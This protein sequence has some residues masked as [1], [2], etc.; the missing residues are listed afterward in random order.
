MWEQVLRTPQHSDCSR[1]AYRPDRSFVSPQSVILSC[2]KLDCQGPA[3]S[4]QDCLSSQISSPLGIL[5]SPLPVGLAAFSSE[6]DASWFV[7]TREWAAIYNLSNR[8][9]C[10][11]H[12]PK[13]SGSSWFFLK[14]AP[15]A[16][17][18]P[19]HHHCWVVLVSDL[20]RFLL[21]V[22]LKQARNLV[23]HLH[24]TAEHN[25]HQGQRVTLQPSRRFVNPLLDLAKIVSIS[26]PRWDGVI[27]PLPVRGNCFTVCGGSE[28]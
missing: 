11:Q 28:W 4:Q 6:G 26:G 1:L 12:S 14:I 22:D 17:H 23:F 2:K 15:V 8:A 19:L 7:S 16:G 9:P 24:Q 21:L 10:E 27:H 3:K 20:D 5:R 25:H 13:G 18:S